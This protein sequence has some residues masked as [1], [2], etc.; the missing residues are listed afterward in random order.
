MILRYKKI[1][2][3][4][5]T[6]LF[7]HIKGHVFLTENIQCRPYFVIPVVSSI[8]YLCQSKADNIIFCGRVQTFSFRG[9]YS[10]YRTDPNVYSS[11]A[12]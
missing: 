2:R 12:N 5:Q 4:V 3:K 10:A 9:R 8:Q 7:I 6:I 1:Y 11:L